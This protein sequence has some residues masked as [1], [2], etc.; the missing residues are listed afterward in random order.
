[1]MSI[2]FGPRLIGETEKTLNAL[3]RNMLVDTDLTEPQWVTLQ[4]AGELDGSV[5]ATGLA[6]AVADRARFDDAAE[7]VAVLTDRGLLADGRPTP[8][9]RELVARVR[10]RIAAETSGIWQDLP[11]GEVVAA[12]R[13]LNEVVRRAR[14][15]LAAS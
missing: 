6:E 3:L 13:V 14:A 10:H 12:G 15:V 5:D 7:I 9:A 2:A 11:E 1:M 8:A 4:L